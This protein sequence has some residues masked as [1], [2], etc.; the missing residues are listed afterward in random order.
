MRT[1]VAGHEARTASDFTEL[2]LGFDPLLF[3]PS[4]PG[5]TPAERRARNAVASEALAEIRQHAASD[6]ATEWDVSYADVVTRTASLTVR[7]RASAV[8]RRSGVTTS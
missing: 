5:E 3:A 4:V 1:F 2:A 6:Q 7:R 8:A